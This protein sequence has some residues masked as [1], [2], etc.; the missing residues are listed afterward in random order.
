MTAHEWAELCFNCKVLFGLTSGKV[1]TELL[2][3]DPPLTPNMVSKE[4]AVAIIGANHRAEIE[5]IQKALRQK[6]L[7]L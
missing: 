2:K 1:T 4:D 3:H 7:M 6:G 5:Q